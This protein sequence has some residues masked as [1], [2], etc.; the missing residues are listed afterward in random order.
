M[1]RTILK[2]N[3]RAM[4]SGRVKT[5]IVSVGIAPHHHAVPDELRDKLRTSL[6]EA[7]VKMDE[8][9]YDFVSLA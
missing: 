1:L 8:A 7:V 3:T 2:T 5:S 4:S 6:K 9:G